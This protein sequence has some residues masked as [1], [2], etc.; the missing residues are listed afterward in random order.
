MVEYHAAVGCQLNIGDTT[1]FNTITDV[2]QQM[3]YELMDEKS[4][5]K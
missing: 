1:C 3:H 2:Q 5:D 4:H